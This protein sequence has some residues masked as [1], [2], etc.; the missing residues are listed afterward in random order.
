MKRGQPHKPRRARAPK[1]GLPHQVQAT[2]RTLA[3]SGSALDFVTCVSASASPA[4]CY[5]GRCARSSVFLSPR[6]RSPYNDRLT[7][8]TLH[9]YNFRR[10]KYMIIWPWSAAMPSADSEANRIRGSRRTRTF[11]PLGSTLSASEQR[12]VT[13]TL[14]IARRSTK[15]SSAIVPLLGRYMTA[16]TLPFRIELY[17]PLEISENDLTRAT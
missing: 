10:V 4:N 1:I 3:L 7:H 9:S 14:M 17:P 2:G 12:A 13:G 6:R 15:D 16:A 5:P 8:C 11:S